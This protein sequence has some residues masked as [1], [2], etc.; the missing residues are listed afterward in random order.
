MPGR[1][2]LGNDAMV[3]TAVFARAVA[4]SF[5]FYTARDRRFVHAIQDQSIELGSSA[6][7]L[8]DWRDATN[9]ANGRHGW[10]PALQV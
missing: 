8:G 10:I 3:A 1:D 6:K 2:I 7:E 9:F 5:V 4:P